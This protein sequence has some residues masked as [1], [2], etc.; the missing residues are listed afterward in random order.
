MCPTWETAGDWDAAQS[1]TT[2]HHEQPAGTKWSPAETLEAGYPATHP[3][4]SYIG[5]WPMEESGGTTMTEVSGSAADDGVLDGGVTPNATPAPFGTSCYSF[6]GAGGSRVDLGTGN[7]PAATSQSFV[8]WFHCAS[9]RTTD[10][11]FFSFQGDISVIMNIGRN[12]TNEIQTFYNGAYY[13]TGVTAAPGV[14]HSLAFCYD[15]SEPGFQVYLDATLIQD[16][17]SPVLASGNGGTCSIGSDDT[18]TTGNFDGEMAQ[19]MA[20]D[21]HLDSTQVTALH[22]AAL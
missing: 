5:Y 8:F 10:N 13:A 11:R 20:F 6:D 15:N 18:D 12:A 4:L 17:A 2:V 16:R 3:E 22:N 7:F 9:D 1:E 19:W 21:S 14:W